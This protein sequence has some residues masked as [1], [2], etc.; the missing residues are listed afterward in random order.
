MIECATGLLGRLMSL[1]WMA[2]RTSRGS[3]DPANRK[4]SGKLANDLILQG[5]EYDNGDHKSK[6][7]DVQSRSH[8]LVRSL[9][10]EIH[11]LLGIST[12]LAPEYPKD[13]FY[14]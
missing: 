11:A 5:G 4:H 3:L 14:Y 9:H 7:N 2:Q 12:Y 1:S 10:V 8:S 13:Y 6:N